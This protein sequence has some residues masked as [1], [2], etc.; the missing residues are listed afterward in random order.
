MSQ[1]TP[2]TNP[3]MQP[4]AFNGQTYFTG[5][6]FHQMYRNNS[7]M[8]GKYKRPADFMRL[9]RSIEAYQSYIDAG[10]IIELLWEDCKQDGNAEI[11][12]LLKSNSYKPIML[13]NAT[14]QVALTHHLDDEVSKNA[15]VNANRQVA[16]GQAARLLAR[17]LKVAQAAAD[18]IRH[19]GG[20]F[21][22]EPQ[23]VN[24]FISTEL[25]KMVGLDVTPLLGNN[26]VEEA[27]MTPTALGKELGV[28]AIE[29][30]RQLFEGGYQTKDEDGQ[31]VPTDEGRKY[32][33]VNPY[34]S[35]NSDHTGYRVLWHR[36]VLDAITKA[37]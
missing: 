3:L 30:N 15:S 20:I 16:T 17:D 28:S 32:C 27:P 29:M 6:Y 35:P 18:L 33:T 10:D 14:A 23:M 19:V 2:F 11:A 22:T 24:A 8:G 26:H 9:V 25:K 31:W 12:L 36:S 13:I 7:D 5:Q 1:I 21:G 37:A 4:I 34:K